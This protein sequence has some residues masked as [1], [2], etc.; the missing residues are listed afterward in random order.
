MANDAGKGGLRS[1]DE[2]IAAT[3]ALESGRAPGLEPSGEMFAQRHHHRWKPQLHA[4][5]LRLWRG[6]EL[7]GVSTC[8]ACGLEV[9]QV[10]VRAQTIAEGWPTRSAQTTYGWET[11]RTPATAWQRSWD[12]PPCDGGAP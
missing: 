10:R 5:K 1:V 7:G 3:E 6:Q 2:L 4:I 11:R 12:M 9:R 8:A